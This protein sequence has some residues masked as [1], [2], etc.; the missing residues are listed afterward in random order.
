[1]S[2]SE[3]L[4]K[5]KNCENAK[6]SPSYK[7]LSFGQKP[8]HL[9]PQFGGRESCL[10][11]RL[12]APCSRNLGVLRIRSSAINWWIGIDN[13]NGVHGTFKGVGANSLPIVR[14]PLG[15]H[16]FQPCWMLSLIIRLSHPNDAPRKI[17]VWIN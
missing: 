5:N 9:V 6:I 1:M 7:L 12:P 13:W 3:N 14:S 4:C 17:S 10:W 8:F 11:G 15:F 16:T 2:F